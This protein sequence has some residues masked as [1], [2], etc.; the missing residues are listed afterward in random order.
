MN[1]NASL[2]KA[3]VGAYYIRPDGAKV[4]RGSAIKTKTA[5]KKLKKVLFERPVVDN[6]HSKTQKPGTKFFGQ[7]GKD[8]LAMWARSCDQANEIAA[9]RRRVRAQLSYKG[10]SA[11]EAKLVFPN[12]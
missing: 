8:R 6:N 12:V 1:D 11:E 2:A 7:K 10:L 9:E 5:K 4:F 3:P